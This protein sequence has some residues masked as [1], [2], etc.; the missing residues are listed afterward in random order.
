[1]K[2]SPLFYIKSGSIYSEQG[3]KQIFKGITVPVQYALENITEKNAD[4]FFSKLSIKGFNL[5]EWEIAWEN[6]ESSG[7]E[8]YNEEYL[9]NLRLILKKAE[10][11]NIFIFI[12]PTMTKW[13]KT[14]GGIGA[15]DWTLDLIGIDIKKLKNKRT[16]LAEKVSYDDYIE[17][18]MFSLFW[19][20]KKYA[21]DFL[22]EGDNIQEYLQNH[23]IAAMKHTARRI[24][25]CKAVIGFGFMKDASKGFIGIQDISKIPVQKNTSILSAL[26]ATEY[27][28]STFETFKIMQGF[29]GIAEKSGGSLTGLLQSSK[30]EIVSDTNIFKEGFNCPWIKSGVWHIENNNTCILD[31]SNFFETNSENFSNEFYRKKFQT[32]FFEA[33]QKKHGHYFF[34]SEADTQEHYTSWIYNESI[35]EEKID[36]TEKE[37]GVITNGDS[38]AFKIIM[39]CKMQTP[40]K[41]GKGQVDIENT[42]K[43][44]ASTIAEANKG[45]LA[46]IV[47]NLDSTLDFSEYNKIYEA[48]KLKEL[49]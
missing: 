13:C 6:I 2:Q 15:P 22:V 32:N 25:D 9:A 43:I 30:K 1:M 23:Y 7:P 42:K 37:G 45:N 16:E 38:E 49:I 24:K 44:L 5:I 8:E 35:C 47:N 20:G 11:H 39:L 21:P 27:Q 34:F 33:F 14:N 19:A 18:T 26:T 48:E 10:E 3:F 4:S 28:L 40:Q 31:N 46:I 36:L 29:N 12:Q 17:K 41:N